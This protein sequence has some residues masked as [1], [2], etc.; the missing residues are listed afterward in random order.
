MIRKKK[1]NHKQLVRLLLIITLLGVLMN[2][3]RIG[4]LSNLLVYFTNWSLIATLI[5]C[6]L[7]YIIAGSRILKIDNAIN[8]HALHHVMYTLSMFM[9]PVVF[10]MYWGVIH[11]KHIPEIK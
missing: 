2:A 4:P 8:M 9:N 7:G 5:T 1:F 3:L 10:I 6:W 11:D